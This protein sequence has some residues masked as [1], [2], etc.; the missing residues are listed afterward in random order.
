VFGSAPDLDDDR[1]SFVAASI[2]SIAFGSRFSGPADLNQVSQDHWQSGLDLCFDVDL[3]LH[4][5]R[6]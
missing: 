6:V 1:S 4:C 3:L 5:F 2:T